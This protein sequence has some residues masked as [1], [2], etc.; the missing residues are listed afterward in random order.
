MFL[1]SRAVGLVSSIHNESYFVNVLNIDFKSSTRNE[2]FRAKDFMHSRS[3][4]LNK[5]TI[6]AKRRICGN[7]SYTFCEMT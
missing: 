1:R 7:K 2:N 5:N 6:L 4:F 3:L